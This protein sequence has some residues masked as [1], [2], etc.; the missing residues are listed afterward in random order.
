MSGE[1]TSPAR[2]FRSAN[3]RLA[4]VVRRGAEPPPLAAIARLPWHPW[5]IVGITCIG[6]FIG[7]LDASIVQIALPI[8]G[9]RFKASLESVSWVSLAYLLAFAASLP[10]FG[11]LCEMFGR[12]LLYLLGYLLFTVATALCGSAP[13]LAWLI[14]F[15]LLQGIGGALLGAN[16]ISIL[17]KAVGA[18]QRARALGIFS[19]A[20]AVGISLG[21]AV[22]GVLLGAYGWRAIFWVAVPFSAAAFVIG[23]LALPQTAGLAEE[24]VFDWWGALFLA[25][26]LITLVLALNQ[27]SAWGV[28]SPSLLFCAA[29]FAILTISLILHERAFAFPLLDFRLFARPAFSCGIVGVVLGYALLYGMFFLMSFALVRGYHDPATLVGVRLAIVPVALGLIAPFSGAL[30]DRLGPRVPSVAGM[31]ISILSLLLLSLVA[32]DPHVS[33]LIGGV[34]LALFGAGLGVF[35]A[36]NTSATVSAAP[37]DLSGEAGALV[38]LM[39]VLGTSLGVVS[40][41][42]MLS[43]QIQ[44]RTGAQSS[45][46]IFEGRHL[47]KAVESGFAMLMVFALIA[48]L[49]SLVRTPRPA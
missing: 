46:V 29:L 49:A 33:R 30:T 1:D 13:N 34:A 39:R 40:A 32:D 44:A 41:S 10:I 8:L 15:R 25:P 21:P 47:L 6:A 7:Q 23:W 2:G 19:A 22:G 5:L 16:S 12:K 17:I 24:K 11:R 48:G 14:F 42:S 26:A 4:D 3:V 18:N 35:I 9:T 28:A 37:P 38:N 27:V 43:W 31:A 45:A 20:Q 36:P